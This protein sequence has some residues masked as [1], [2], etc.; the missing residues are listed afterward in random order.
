MRSL[1]VTMVLLFA[2]VVYG[3]YFAGLEC[4]QNVNKTDN[5]IFERSVGNSFEKKEYSIKNDIIEIG[6]VTSN[7][8]GYLFYSDEFYGVTISITNRSN[9]NEILN[10]FNRKYGSPYIY[11]KKRPIIWLTDDLIIIFTRFNTHLSQ[12]Q[13]FCR[14]FY[15][16]TFKI[17]GK[18]ISKASD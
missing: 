8:I 17:S 12:V 16:E 2:P 7:I 5:L 4:S 18:D 15:E 6:K 1:F 9:I 3:D 14:K 11:S 13:I 10:F